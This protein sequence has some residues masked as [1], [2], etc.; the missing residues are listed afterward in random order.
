M[1]LKYKVRVAVVRSALSL[2]VVTATFQSAQIESPVNWPVNVAFS[3]S[4]G[5][6]NTALAKATD[7]S[8]MDTLTANF[9]AGS[10]PGTP[11]AFILTQPSTGAPLGALNVL[12]TFGLS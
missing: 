12:Y 6:T 4:P 8:G 10:V 2:G 7:P 11:L 5:L 1:K 3:V 9:F